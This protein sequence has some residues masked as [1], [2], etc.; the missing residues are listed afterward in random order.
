MKFNFFN[1]PS[2]KFESFLNELEITEINLLALKLSGVALTTSFESVDGRKSSVEVSGDSIRFTDKSNKTSKINDTSGE[3]LPNL[4]AHIREALLFKIE[5]AKEITHLH[6]N[7]QAPSEGELKGEEWIRVTS[8]VLKESLKNAAS[9]K[10][11]SV[12]GNIFIGKMNGS[13]LFTI[14][15]QCY[16][17]DYTYSF[18]NNGALNISV[19]DD[20]NFERG[21]SKK[22]AYMGEFYNNR[23]QL[24]DE[25]FKVIFEIFASGNFKIFS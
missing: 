23:P 6:P 5:N 14:R 8:H 21:H 17:L 1:K 15:V 24:L 25:I 4:L 7:I 20:K 16:N 22:A 11:L 18:L 12:E 10:D 9:N 19:Y 2:D 3:H 13:D